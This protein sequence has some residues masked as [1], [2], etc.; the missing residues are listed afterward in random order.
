MHFR[1]MNCGE[2]LT[3]R[4]GPDGVEVAEDED[5]PVRLGLVQVP[6]D[7]LDEELGA[8]VRV[9]SLT[10]DRKELE[11]RQRLWE[12]CMRADIQRVA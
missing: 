2:P 9:R 12:S 6:Q 10:F 11:P 1:S 8:T 7:L 4:V 3:G 5:A